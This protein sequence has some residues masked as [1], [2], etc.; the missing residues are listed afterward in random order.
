[1]T[2]TVTLDLDD[3]GAV[4]RIWQEINA[5]DQARRADPK[6]TEA[7]ERRLADAVAAGRLD[8]AGAAEV[9]AMLDELHPAAVLKAHRQDLVEDRPMPA[10]G[11]W[12]SAIGP[13]PEIDAWYREVPARLAGVVRQMARFVDDRQVIAEGAVAHARRLGIA[14]D[15]FIPIIRDAIRALPRNRG[16]HRAG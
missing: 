12:G 6:L 10:A 9:R 4:D 14:E 1:M 5:R 7:I 16:G 2:R 13:P 3:A 15:T 8:E 11:V